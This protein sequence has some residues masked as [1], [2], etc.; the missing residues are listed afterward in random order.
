MVSFVNAQGS[1]RI[2]FACS[3]A[4]LLTFSSSNIVTHSTGSIKGDKYFF[5][6]ES[7]GGKCSSE[8]KLFTKKRR[9]TIEKDHI[10]RT[11]QYLTFYRK[12]GCDLLNFRGVKNGYR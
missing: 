2:R 7:R 12:I 6:Y 10:Y 4:L 3:K 8:T 9:N 1:V 11:K 5:F